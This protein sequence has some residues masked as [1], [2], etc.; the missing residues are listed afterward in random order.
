MYRLMRILHQLLC[1]HEWTA[2]RFNAKFFECHHCGKR[3]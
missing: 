2:D 1:R 3:K